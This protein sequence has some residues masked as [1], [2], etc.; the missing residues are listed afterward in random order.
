[1]ARMLS[2]ANHEGR[3]YPKIDELE[4]QLRQLE[5][6]VNNKTFLKDYSSA[7]VLIVNIHRMLSNAGY[8]NSTTLLDTV[9]TRFQG[10]LTRSVYALILQELADVIT[11]RNYITDF[12][13]YHDIVE[14]KEDIKIES[15]E[16]G[17]K[18]KVFN[19]KVDVIVNTDSQANLTSPLYEI[20]TIIRKLG[21]V[22]TFHMFKAISKVAVLSVK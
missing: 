4:S 14:D 15:T 9:K 7:I 12:F 3:L 20:A 5:E 10:N 19:T 16:Y 6:M 11:K 2:F 18:L 22:G 17:T 13:K 21:V 1:M 8:E